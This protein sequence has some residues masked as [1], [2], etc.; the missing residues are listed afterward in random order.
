ME[1]DYYDDT[2][3]PAQEPI[4]QILAEYLWLSGNGTQLRSQTRIV[5]PSMGYVEGQLPAEAFPMTVV[6]DGMQVFLKPRRVFKDPFRGGEHVLVMCD[7]FQVQGS[8]MV[9]LG[10]GTP[11]PA[12][13]VATASNHRVHCAAMMEAA[14]A[15]QPVFSVEQQY[16]VHR[17]G[18]DDS[19]DED[20]GGD[21]AGLRAQS[22]DSS[23]TGCD[24]LH[25]RARQQR[26]QQSA[27]HQSQRGKRQASS[28]LGH[29]RDRTAYR[30]PPQQTTSSDLCEAHQQHCLSAG[31][32]VTGK[33][34][35][36]RAST[37]SYTIGPC[38]G[39]ELGDQLLASRY[40]LL[41]LAE[42][43]D[44]RVTFESLGQAC[45]PSGWSS[46]ALA[47]VQQQQQEQ[48]QRTHMR[49]PLSCFLH[50]ST[51]LS[52]HPSV[53]LLV[54]QLYATKLQG[55]EDQCSLAHGGGQQ[56]ATHS[57]HPSP[58]SACEATAYRS[59]LRVSL[60]EASLWRGCGHLVDHRPAATADPYLATMC[61]VASTL[62]LTPPGGR[63][64]ADCPP[65]PTPAPASVCPQS[66][67]I[68]GPTSQPTPSL[69]EMCRL[70][71]AEW[72]AAGFVRYSGARPAGR[73][74]GRR[75]GG[76]VTDSGPDS[77]SGAQ[78]EVWL[79]ARNEHRMDSHCS[80]AS[81]GYDGDGSGGESG[82]SDCGVTYQA[83]SG[84]EEDEG[85]C[86]SVDE[87]DSASVASEELLV[88]ALD[89]MDGSEPAAPLLMCA[90]G[91][92]W[93]G[94][95]MRGGCSFGMQA[96]RRK[97]CTG[98]VGWQGTEDPCI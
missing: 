25:T 82:L 69:S 84:G 83:G 31:M 17:P 12:S 11:V 49:Q 56:Q 14:E 27:D 68:L 78:R 20:H 73:R 62:D 36:G 8:D 46:R 48:Q 53:G 87:M 79:S 60:P 88:E 81:T 67:G 66:Q 37:L 30:N 70:A 91:P 93:V 71:D 4:A 74:R 6:Q 58:A 26:R 41:R 35:T 29:N 19:S 34:H 54:L 98:Q 86:A 1:P 59:K 10:S 21:A 47:P 40:T 32:Q 18:P 16:E 95:V 24:T 92:A 97:S 90:V 65:A 45:T 13:L 33:L 2:P 39:V 28:G 57:H 80:G 94:A 44:L 77:V 3:V 61:L 5:T 50:Y 76:E 38:G 23:H 89:R 55:A 51:A 85:D 22:P 63:D 43:L 15:E 75:S 42:Q 64:V 96:S 72:A 7:T 52:R 9:G